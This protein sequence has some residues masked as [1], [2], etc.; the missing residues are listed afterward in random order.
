MLTQRSRCGTLRHVK[1]TTRKRKNQHGGHREHSGRK[2]LFPNKSKR[3]LAMKFTADGRQLLEQLVDR[4][5]L[6]R[7]DV[8]EHLLVT[9][10]RDAEIPP[11]DPYPKK[12]HEALSVRLS[13]A[14]ASVLAILRKASGQSRGVIG[15]Y[16]VRTFGPRATFPP[17][18]APDRLPAPIKRPRRRTS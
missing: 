9:C 10:K 1:A 17:K 11:R 7:N 5:G 14:G 8:I 3:G 16:F 15:E 4:S 6:S 13:P 18:P 12:Y 2:T